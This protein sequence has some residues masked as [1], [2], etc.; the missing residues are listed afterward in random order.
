MFSVILNNIYL[1]WPAFFSSCSSYIKVVRLVFCTVLKVNGS[2]TITLFWCKGPCIW[3]MLLIRQVISPLA[4]VC[5]M[6][7]DAHHYKRI[8]FMKLW[9][10]KVDIWDTFSLAS[11]QWHPQFD[12][13][14]VYSL[15]GR[16][17]YHKISW[18]LEAARLYA[19]TMASLRQASRQ[20]RC[21]GACQISEQLK[22]SRP[23]SRDFATSRDLTARR[24]SD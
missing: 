23:E 19:I 1:C 17:S 2:C 5:L 9:G 18:S 14:G 4:E 21:R 11:L 13:Q 3:Y 16:A 12:I 20:Q 8:V 15:S 6:F 7:I 24:P 10:W 22:K